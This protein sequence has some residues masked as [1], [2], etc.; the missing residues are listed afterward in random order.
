MALQ[1]TVNLTRFTPWA[2]SMHT[3][4]ALWLTN[5]HSIK[6]IKVVT[7][8]PQNSL[9]GESLGGLG[10]CRLLI[11]LNWHKP[12]LKLVHKDIQEWVMNFHLPSWTHTNPHW[13]KQWKQMKA[14][15]L[16]GCLPVSLPE[17]TGRMED[18]KEFGLPRRRIIQEQQKGTL[19]YL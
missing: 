1:W 2:A 13:Y 14:L 16:P 18:Q 4:F 15:W 11:L 12:S 5:I 19:T 17:F 9:A 6:N 7:S 10:H 8:H 3:I